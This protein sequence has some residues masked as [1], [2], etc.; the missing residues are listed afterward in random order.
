MNTKFLTTKELEAMVNDPKFWDNMKGPDIDS[1]R[2]N[3][4]F[5][6]SLPIQNIL[7]KV[8]LKERV[9]LR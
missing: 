9:Q 7:K 4:Y 3:H 1:G 5:H 8:I 2:G 6:Q